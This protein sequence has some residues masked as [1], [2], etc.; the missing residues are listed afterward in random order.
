MP[1]ACLFQS[2]GLR[3]M[4]WLRTSTS[5]GPGEGVGRSSTTRL[6]P[7]PCKTAAECVAELDIV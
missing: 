3:P 1:K 2:I 5:P 4:A 6:L 7:I